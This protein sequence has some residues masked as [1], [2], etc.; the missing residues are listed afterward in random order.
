MSIKIIDITKVSNGETVIS[1]KEMIESLV[2]ELND[3]NHRYYV[4]NEPIMSDYDFDMKLKQLEQL[5]AEE[6]YILPYSPTQRI[7]SDL[8]K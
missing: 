4:L 1:K 3:A 7:G 5:E 2:D 8:Q 6:N